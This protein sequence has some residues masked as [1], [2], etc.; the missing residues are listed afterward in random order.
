MSNYPAYCHIEISG[1][2]LVVSDDLRFDEV[3]A[4]YSAD[5]DRLALEGFVGNAHTGDIV[6]IGETLVIRRNA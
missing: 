2:A 6:Q 4:K 3:R 5:E 1:A